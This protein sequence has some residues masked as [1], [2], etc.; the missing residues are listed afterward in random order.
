MEGWQNT[1]ELVLIVLL[2]TVQTAGNCVLIFNF[3]DFRWRRLVSR[4]KLHDFIHSFSHANNKHT[5]D[6]CKSTLV[7]DDS[8][9][10]RRTLLSFKAYDS[11]AS[12][13]G[14]IAPCNVMLQYTIQLEE[15]FVKHFRNLQKVTCVGHDLLQ[16][17]ES[18]Q[19]NQPCN[20]FNKKHLLMLFTGLRIYYCLKFA[21]RELRLPGRKNK[22]YFKL[23]F[24]SATNVSVING[25][26]RIFPIM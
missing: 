12:Y 4:H 11:D 2:L 24:V 6:L 18:I 17:L 26:F 8:Y 20:S 19:L 15:T 13:G 22:K 1:A 5:C 14:L 16:L 9:D 7:D 3:T 21:N 23:T 10:E 25:L